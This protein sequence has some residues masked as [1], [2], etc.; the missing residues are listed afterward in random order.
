MAAR[1]SKSF[2]SHS[3][4]SPRPK[5]SVNG[6][7]EMTKLRY[8]SLG[9]TE[10]APW[11]ERCDVSRGFCLVKMKDFSRDR[12]VISMSRHS[13]RRLF[14][15]SAKVFLFIVRFLITELRSLY[16]NFMLWSVQDLLQLM[17]RAQSR[18]RAGFG[19]DTVLRLLQ[20]DIKEMFTYLSR[21]RIVASILWLSGRGRAVC[22]RQGVP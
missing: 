1:L 16:P 7:L 14:H 4:F 22:P 10:L 8:R 11:S 21:Q 20:Y 17:E 6:V 2:L 13:A 5:L 19:A 15:Q 9:L 18:L 3:S 12:G